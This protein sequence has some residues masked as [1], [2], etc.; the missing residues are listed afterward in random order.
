MA[1]TIAVEVSSLTSRTAVV[2]GSSPNSALPPGNLMMSSLS[3]PKIPSKSLSSV[4]RK[5]KMPAALCGLKGLVRTNKSLANAC[6]LDGFLLIFLMALRIVLPWP[7]SLSVW[8]VHH[9]FVLFGYS[10]SEWSDSLRVDS[11]PK[12]CH[13]WPSRR[14]GEEA[15]TGC[16]RFQAQRARE[17]SRLREGHG[18]TGHRL[19]WSW[20]YRP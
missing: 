10:N 1:G 3:T 5:N 6:H 11:L 7:I 9:S 2:Q 17:P 20:Q 12:A 18:T 4:K 14:R 16:L 15:Q 8:F 19:G 13:T